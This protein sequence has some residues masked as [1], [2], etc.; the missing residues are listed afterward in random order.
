RLLEFYWSHPGFIAPPGRRNEVVSFVRGGL[1]DLSGS[2][3]SFDWGIEVP[4]A[5]DHVMYVWLDALTNYISAVGYPDTGSET[6]R[7][8]WPADLHMEIGRASC[9]DRV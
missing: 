9:R 1:L 7:K 5:P 2:R 3:T 4:G 8:F 6:Y